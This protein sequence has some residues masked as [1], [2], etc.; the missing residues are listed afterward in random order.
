MQTFRTVLYVKRKGLY[1]KYMV[2]KV[3]FVAVATS[4]VYTGGMLPVS[5]K[6]IT[7]AQS[8]KGSL[9]SVTSVPLSQLLEEKQPIIG[10]S[11]ATEEQMLAFARAVNPN[12]PAELPKL[13]LEI[14]KK[15]GIRGD[16]AFCQMI[17]ETGYHRFG[18]IVEANQYNYAGIGA[19]GN[20]KTNKGNSFQSPEQGV[21]AH[22]QHLYAYATKQNLP[23]GEKLVDPRFKYVARGIAP[24]WQDL[25]GRWAVPGKG[26][27]EDIL[28]IYYQM[29]QTPTSSEIQ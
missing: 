27:G 8:N 14:G 15:Y 16:I 11:I 17:K 21:L 5:S 26:Y 23:Q 6:H 28:R 24:S 7:Y 25:N 1:N 2:R 10:E 13:Y 12:F 18:G 29:L 9:Y 22:I 3:V 19:T 20:S 4:M